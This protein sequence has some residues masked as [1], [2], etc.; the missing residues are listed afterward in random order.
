MHCIIWERDDFLNVFHIIPNDLTP[1]TVCLVL[2]IEKRENTSS[3]R[4]QP[5]DRLIGRMSLYCSLSNSL[6]SR[7]MV[8]RIGGVW[9]YMIASA[10]SSQA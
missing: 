3:T 7:K 9:R 4:M 8:C 6:R 5:V 10:I 1:L 2:I